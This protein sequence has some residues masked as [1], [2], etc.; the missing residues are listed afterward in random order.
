[1]KMTCLGVCGLLL[2]MSVSHFARAQNLVPNGDF[3]DL[4]LNDAEAPILDAYGLEQPASWFRSVTNPQSVA[5]PGTELITPANM[6]NIA[7]NNLGDDSDGVGTNSIA[8]NYVPD[9]GVPPLGVGMDWRS[10]GFATTPGETLIFSFDVKFHGVSQQAPTGMP[11]GG[12]VQIRSFTEQA[13]DGGTAGTFKGEKNITVDAAVYA[14]DVWHTIVNAVTIPAEGEW[15][16]LRISS[17]LFLPPVHTGGQILFDKF[18]VQRL[19]ADFDG[20]GDVD[21]DDLTMFW[22]PAF[23]VTAAADAD[24]DGD[25]DGDD[26]LAWQRQLGLGVPAGGQAGA[27]SIPEPAAGVMAGFVVAAALAARRSA[28]LRGRRRL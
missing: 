7:G 2:S 5:I 16:D 27:Q 6:N 15:T 9:P 3:E 8:L 19:T 1:M 23:G 26:F 25:S 17:N 12:F 13:A 20:D 21:G 18:T 24:G 28:R 14:P 4:Q 10:Q 22:K 11:E